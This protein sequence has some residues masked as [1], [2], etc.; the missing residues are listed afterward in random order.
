MK[1]VTLLLVGLFAI[2]GIA[3]AQASAQASEKESIVIIDSHFDASLIDGDVVQVC[4]VAARLCNRH[5][6]PRNANQF[7]SYNHG[8]IMA[9]VVRAHNPNATLILVRAANL[10][11]SVVTGIGLG[12]AL[13]WVEANQGRYNIKS[14]SFSYNAGNGTRCTPASP[15]KNVRVAHQEIVDSVANL[16]AAGTTVFAASGNYG[17][18]NRIDYPACIPDVVAVGSSLYRGSQAQSDIVHRGFT[19]TSSAI[20][21]SRTSLQD[22][23][24]LVSNGRHPLRVGNTTSVATAITAATS[25]ST[26]PAVVAAAPKPGPAPNPRAELGASLDDISPLLKSVT[27]N[28]KSDAALDAINAQKLIADL[29]KLVTELESVYNN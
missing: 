13:D 5:D 2:A 21:S 27:E 22:S 18:G 25:I 24:A 3:P 26:Q 29:K 7:R 4:V 12:L 6:L 23:S 9:D 1:K 19:F 10:T 15:G 11:T 17:A 20:T 16:R 14:V 8:T 28:V